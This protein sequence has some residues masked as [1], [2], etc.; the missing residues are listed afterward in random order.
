MMPDWPARMDA[1]TAALYLGI[2]INTLREGSL[3]GR[4]PRSVKDGKR[5][6]WSRRQLDDFVDAQFGAKPA[7]GSGSA[8]T[9]WDELT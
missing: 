3:R 4:Y 8:G 5:V 6:L 7:D 2:S 1:G 9:S